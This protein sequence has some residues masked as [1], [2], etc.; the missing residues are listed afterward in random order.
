MLVALLGAWL[1]LQVG[2]RTTAPIGPV[3]TRLT[4]QLSISGD[5]DVRAG[6]LGTLLL[7]THDAPLRITV[8]VEG[9]KLADARA[10]VDDPQALTGLQSWVTHDLRAAIRELVIRSA[11]SA[12]VGALLLGLLVYRRSVRRVAFVG[13][14]AV[15][16]ITANGAAA[17]HSW[18]PRAISEPRYTGLLA[19]AP[20]LVGNAKDIVAGFGSY[21]EEL[22]KLVGNVSKLYDVT[23]TLPAY[24]PDGSTIRV[25]HV[26]DIHLNPAAWE[27]IGSVSRQF[28]VQVIVDAGDISDHGSKAERR[29][30]ENIA[31]L[32]L[33]YVWVRGNHDSMAIQEAIAKLPNAVVLDRGETRSVAGLTFVGDG[34]PRFTPDKSAPVLD[35]L[36]LAEAGRLL[37]GNVRALTAAPDVAVVHDPT[38]IRPLDGMV[39]LL[40]AGHTHR[41]GT[42]LLPGGSRL[43]VQGSTGGAGLRAL[44]GAEPTPLEL[45]VLYFDAA[46]KRL[47]AW[48]DITVGG[49]GLTSAQIHRVLAPETAARLG[50]TNGASKN[51]PT[52]ADPLPTATPRPTAAPG[53]TAGPSAPPRATP[54]RAVAPARA[55]AATPAPAPNPK[56]TQAPPEPTPEPSRSFPPIVPRVPTLP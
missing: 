3:E 53:A 38:M 43:F 4:A 46:S 37:A 32:A 36:A 45:S 52:G 9:I 6:P 18:N 10:L 56:P 21:S 19:G 26:A 22:A 13:V 54:Q 27:V 14:A 29:F 24:Q 49:L 25:L 8:S 11:V 34:D 42:E 15:G 30:V 35:D 23:S 47:Q 5:T 17:A 51:A 33:P 40:L 7:D 1:G 28:G 20:A 39:P 16:L 41:R 12:V 2:G 50:S 44:E 55:P 31:D 48:D